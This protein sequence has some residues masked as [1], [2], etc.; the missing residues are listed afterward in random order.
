MGEASTGRARAVPEEGL[1]LL[2]QGSKDVFLPFEEFPNLILSER[3]SVLHTHATFFGRNIQ[4][5]YG[6]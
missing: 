5:A 6:L 1:F 2:H 3:L 4:W